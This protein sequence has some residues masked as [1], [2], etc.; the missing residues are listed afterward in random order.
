MAITKDSGRQ[1]PVVARVVTAAA[2]I[3]AQATYAAIDVPAGAI[4]TG[5]YAKV[6]TAFD[7]SV[8]LDIGD[9][10]DVDR[11]IKNDASGTF[12]AVAALAEQTQ[13]SIVMLALTGYKYTAP[14]TIDVKLA[15]AANTT[16]TLELVVEYIVDGREAFS[17]G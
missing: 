16:G 5:G 11:Y 17:E 2:D 13:N 1:A 10:G 9:D 6:L 8:T 7:S 4:V 15:G 12:P 3:S 14:N